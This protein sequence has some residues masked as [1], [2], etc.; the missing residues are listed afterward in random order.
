M[1]LVLFCDL[2]FWLL[3]GLSLQFHEMSEHTTYETDAGINSSQIMFDLL[4][5]W[6]YYSSSVSFHLSWILFAFCPV[7]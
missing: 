1:S 7:S 6:G 4:I 5:G 3:L 2:L